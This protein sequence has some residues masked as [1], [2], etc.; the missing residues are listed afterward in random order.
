MYECIYKWKIK[1]FKL[2]LCENKHIE[3]EVIISLTSF[4]P[5]LKV[6]SLTLKSL[7]IQSVKPSKIIVW[8]GD[9]TE[10]KMLSDELLELEKYGIEYEFTNEN[11]K[12][13]KKYFY[14]M[15]QYPESLI[16]TVDDDV[17]Y[18]E[19]MVK[20]LIKCHKK[21]PQDICARRIHKIEFSENKKNIKPYNS[22]T[23]EYKPKINEAKLEYF[24]T[25]V[26]GVLYPPHSLPDIAFCKDEIE[27]YCLNADDIW[28]K[29]MEIIN[30]TKVVW[31]NCKYPHPIT[32]DNS[33]LT[34]LNMENVENGQNDNYINSLLTRYQIDINRFF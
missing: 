8:F 19:N 17:I 31:A 16:I 22:W 21:Y 18:D 10:K 14:V 3:E 33:Q 28:L 11:I 27:K 7:L 4:P 34:R 29:I 1:H 15:Q 9:D 20:S 5:R 25:G 32:I 26:G 23:H 24:A 6:L 30:G 2:F 13:H 12:P